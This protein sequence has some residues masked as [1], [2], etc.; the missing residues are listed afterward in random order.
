MT[1]KGQARRFS[2]YLLVTVGFAGGVLVVQAAD[3]VLPED[4]LIVE[5]PRAAPVPLPDALP[6]LFPTG[7]RAL[8]DAPQGPAGGLAAD[9]ATPITI[10]LD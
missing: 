2:R 6:D 5:V 4:G 1:L 10:A 8:P 3:P 7:A 9:H